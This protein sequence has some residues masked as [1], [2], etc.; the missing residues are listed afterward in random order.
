M[1][2]GVLARRAGPELWVLVCHGKKC[3][4]CPKNSAKSLGD[5]VQAPGP[6]SSAF[7]D[8]HTA[9]GDESGVRQRGWA[10]RGNPSPVSGRRD[11]S[12]LAVAGFSDV[13][14]CP[15]L[16]MSDTTIVTT[17]VGPSPVRWN[18]MTLPIDSHL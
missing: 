14:L 8:A 9:L 16:P 11:R 1:V 12:G 2:L 7:Q 15:G 5:C 3:V 4:L 6:I 10:L 17:T 18:C 13:S